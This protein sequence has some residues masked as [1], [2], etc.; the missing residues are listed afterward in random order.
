MPARVAI[1]GR[2]GHVRA[3]FATVAAVRP[4]LVT[5]V[6]CLGSGCASSHRPAVASL[7]QPSSPS[8]EASSPLGSE[9]PQLPAPPPGEPSSDAG[10]GGTIQ[11]P[12]GLALTAEERLGELDARLEESLAEFDGKLLREQE[13]AATERSGG[14]AVGTIGAVAGSIGT[15]VAAGPTAGAAADSGSTTGGSADPRGGSESGRARVPERAGLGS[16]TRNVPPDIPDARD[17][18][19]VARQLREAAESEQDPELRARL[20][21]EYRKYKLGRLSKEKK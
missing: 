21:E 9:Q 18:D 16:E 13:L 17:D 19:V 2:I 15:A 1:T 8:T 3:Q 5:A 11:Q 12:Q 10:T 6:L 7:P 14:G 20:W 4:L